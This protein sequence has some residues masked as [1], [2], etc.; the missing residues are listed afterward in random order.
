MREAVVASNEDETEQPAASDEP[1]QPQSSG[2]PAQAPPADL[3]WMKTE[4]IHGAG[5]RGED[6]MRRLREPDEEERPTLE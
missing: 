5:E 4:T 6:F 1:A 2:E 3:N